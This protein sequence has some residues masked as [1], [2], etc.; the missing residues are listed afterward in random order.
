MTS[1]ASPAPPDGP[2]AAPP[3]PRWRPLCERNFFLSGVLALFFF[4]ASAFAGMA[5]VRLL[6]PGSSV[7]YVLG[8]FML[9]M[10][11]ALGWL[12]VRHLVA[13]CVLVLAPVLLPVLLLWLLY[14]YVRG[15]S[16]TGAPVTTG[17][18]PDPTLLLIVPACALMAA[19]TGA[20]GAFEA[21]LPYGRAIGGMAAT[22]AAWGLVLALLQLTGVLPDEDRSALDA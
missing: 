19:I 2:P 4:F 15:K 17:W 18:R 5:A 6:V 8:S 3:P 13:A 10:G 12:G 11:W 21:G 1:P 22:G 20:V 14:R 9:P 7:A 16:L